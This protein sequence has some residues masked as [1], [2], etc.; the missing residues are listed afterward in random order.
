MMV[1]DIAHSVI[2]IWEAG[3]N[4]FRSL[5]D[6]MTLKVSHWQWQHEYHGHDQHKFAFSNQE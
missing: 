2:E 1:V 3:S 4:D 5:R 6:I